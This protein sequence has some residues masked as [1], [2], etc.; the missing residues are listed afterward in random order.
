MRYGYCFT[1]NKY[2]NMETQEK[3][4]LKLYPDASLIKDALLSRSNFESL[5]LTLRDGDEVVL[6][7]ITKLYDK[8]IVK[9]EF[10]TIFDTVLN[11]YQRIFSRGADI[12]ILDCPELNSSI[13]RNAILH[14]I[15]K[16]SSSTEMA[17]S[18]IMEAQ[19]KV[20]LLDRIN[21]NAEKNASIKNSI[22]LQRSNSS[23][24]RASSYNVRKEK[25]CKD[26]IKEHLID[27][28]GDQT[29]EEIIEH[30]K[31]SRNT[32]FK[33]KRELLGSL[34]TPKKK[35]SAPKVK[36]S[37]KTSPEAS[38]LRSPSILEDK[39]DKSEGKEE[40]ALKKETKPS[41]AKKPSKK[42]TKKEFSEENGLSGQ[43]SLFDFLG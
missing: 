39:V 40:K 11:N 4:I 14:N 21:K 43:M 29:N 3:A 8:E 28:G 33:Y 19:M 12:I 41:P 5:I 20:I 25:P 34:S 9:K 16:G 17:V 42:T 15:V 37:S 18:E 22:K 7:S 35:Q 26:Y 10:D 24:K 30:L 38:Q 13:F 27:L 2:Q 36:S 32:Y 31:I 23:P 6:T 1:S